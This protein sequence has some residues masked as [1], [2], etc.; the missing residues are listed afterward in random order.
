M[1]KESKQRRDQ[2]KKP[3]MTLKERRLKKHEKKAQR[4]QHHIDE[5]IDE[6][7]QQ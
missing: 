5:H 4:E 3:Q 7:D 6:F 2:K 1:A